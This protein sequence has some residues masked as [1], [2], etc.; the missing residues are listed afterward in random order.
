MRMLILTYIVQQVIPNVCTKYQTKVREKSRECHNH[1]PQPF[2]GAVVPEK[3]LTQMS[4]CITMEKEM[5]EKE[6]KIAN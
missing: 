5:E 3:S 4:S 6:E 2:P 1:K